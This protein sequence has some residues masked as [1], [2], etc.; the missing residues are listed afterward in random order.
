MRITYLNS[1]LVQL[2]VSPVIRS[3]RPLLPFS[4]MDGVSGSHTRRIHKKTLRMA[5]TEAIE[6]H[7]LQPGLALFQ[8]FGIK[9]RLDWSWF[10]IF[11]LV[12]TE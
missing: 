9:I 4:Q 11:L 1:R 6:R 3:A 7:R 2:G 5:K 12:L 10:F 8:N